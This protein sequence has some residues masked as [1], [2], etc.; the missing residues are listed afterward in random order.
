MTCALVEHNV[1]TVQHNDLP[2][3]SLYKKFCSLIVDRA[4]EQPN[5]EPAGLTQL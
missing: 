3:I 1:P 4:A 5:L 2:Y